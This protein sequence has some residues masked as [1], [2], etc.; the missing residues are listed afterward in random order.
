[1]VTID[2]FRQLALSFP[3]MIEAPHFDKSSFK[4]AKKIVVTLNVKENR[5]CRKLSEI[6]QDLFSTFDRTVIYPVPN[7]WGKQGWTLVNLHKVEE[8]TLLDALTAAYCEVAPKKLS[9]L[10]RS[11]PEE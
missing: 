2:T 7:K 8:E 3:A 4:V 10:I 1:M 11:K 6:D 9:A 5:C